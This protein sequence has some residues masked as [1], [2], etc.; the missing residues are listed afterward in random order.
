[1]NI[2]DQTQVTT[3]SPGEGDPDAQARVAAFQ[4]WKD[5]IDRGEVTFPD[6][7][8]VTTKSACGVSAGLWAN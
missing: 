5:K 3:K 8:Q 2:P 7:S 4:Q 6:Q 1:M